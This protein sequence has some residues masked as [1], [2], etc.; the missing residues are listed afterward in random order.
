MTAIEVACPVCAQQ[1]YELCRMPDGSTAPFTHAE[2]LEFAASERSPSTN[3]PE[4]VKEAIDS[5]IEGLI[6]P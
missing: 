5:A 4:I 3:D 6:E 2:R 1:P